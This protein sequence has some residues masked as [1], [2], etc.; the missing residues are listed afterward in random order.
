MFDQ[1]DYDHTAALLRSGDDAV[2]RA[3]L[4]NNLNIILAALDATKEAAKHEA[5][6]RSEHL[7]VLLGMVE[8]SGDAAMWE[9]ARWFMEERHAAL[10]RLPAEPPPHHEEIMREIAEHD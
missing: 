9:R 1:D 3:T 6:L 10:T 8:D 2:V 7:L 5:A 4:S